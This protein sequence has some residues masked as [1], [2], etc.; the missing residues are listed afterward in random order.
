MTFPMMISVKVLQEVL[1]P[2][3]PRPSHSVDLRT[4]SIASESP[5]RSVMVAEMEESVDFVGPVLVCTQVGPPWVD[6]FGSPL[7]EKKV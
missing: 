1:R 6:E 5:P 7:E 3:H 2:Q 4:R